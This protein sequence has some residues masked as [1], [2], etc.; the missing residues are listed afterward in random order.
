MSQVYVG[1]PAATG[2]P[3]KQLKGYAKTQLQ[4]GETKRVTVALDPR[5]F[6]Y[7]SVANHSWTVMP[8]CYQILIGDSSRN[9]P[10]RASVGQGGGACT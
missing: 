10:L 4:A 1:D 8:G 9:L 6:A 5:A 3:P 7:W 2:E